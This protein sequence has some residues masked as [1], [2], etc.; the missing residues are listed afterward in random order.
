VTTNAFSLA[1]PA[2]WPPKA[3]QATPNAHKAAA[4]SLSA[5]ASVAAASPVLTGVCAGAPLTRPLPP[6]NTVIETFGPKFIPPATWTFHPGIDFRV[7]VGSPV[8][9]THAGVAVLGSNAQLGSY[10]LLQ[11]GEGTVLYAPVT[12]APGV[13]GKA[14][15]RGDIVATATST[16]LHLAYAPQGGVFAV[17]TTID[18]MP[19]FV[20]GRQLVLGAADRTCLLKGRASD[21]LISRAARRLF[22]SLTCL[23]PFVSPLQ[24]PCLHCLLHPLMPRHRQRRAGAADL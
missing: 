15:A 20:A 21:L 10:V 6:D 19:C 17:A 14:L 4:S 12:P 8:L 13:A 1:C 3:V 24:P 18:P 2:G 7:A 22:T 16:F 5:S 9:A 23:P 11:G